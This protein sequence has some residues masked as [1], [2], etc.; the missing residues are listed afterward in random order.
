[1]ALGDQ[2]AYFTVFLHQLHIPFVG[3]PSS[4]PRSDDS[5]PESIWIDFLAH[6]NCPSLL[7]HCRDVR[8][9]SQPR[10]HAAVRPRFVSLE[11]RPLIDKYPKDKE[12][13]YVK[14]EVVLRICSGGFD[15]LVDISRSRLRH[16]LQDSQRFVH[17]ST[18][19]LI[20]HQADLA[21]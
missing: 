6:L 5:Q 2:L 14:L 21:R 13:V 1:M 9:A 8:T 20:Y 4:V 17:A 12:L 18:P 19:H 16:E 10:R 7:N 11:C 3:I 15:D